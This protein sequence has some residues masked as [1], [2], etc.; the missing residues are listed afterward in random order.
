MKLFRMLGYVLLALIV[1]VAVAITFTIGWRPII[2]PR[3]R[4]VTDRRFEATPER[5]ARGDYLVNAV[6][7]CFGCHSEVDWQNEVI[8]PATRGAG[9]LIFDKSIPWLHTANITQDKETGIGGWSDDEIARA[10][11]EGIGREGRTL[12]PMMPYQKFKIMSDEDLASII[13]YLRTV[14]PVRQHIPPTEAPFPVNRFINA[15]PEPITE[16]V[17]E[18]DLSTPEKRG[19]YLVT[20]AGCADCHTPMDEQGQPRPGLEFAGGTEFQNPVGRVVSVNITPDPSG[21]PYYTDDLFVEAMRTGRVRARKLHPQMPYVI[22]R[23]MTDEDL[24]GVFAYLKTLPPV[25]HRVNNTD[26]PT[27]CPLCMVRHGLGDQN[28]APQ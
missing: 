14:P 24:R 22:Y 4:A 7:A 2:G 20:L 6:A 5:L 3:A 1:L 19:E 27:D 15:V 17:P 9:H 12:F 26:P 23:N 18:P 10:V 16:P 8:P 21:I 28:A 11:R 25:A 13:V